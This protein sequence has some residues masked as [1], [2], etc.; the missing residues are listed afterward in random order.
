MV[1]KELPD[2]VGEVHQAPSLVDLLARSLEGIIVE[3]LH[4]LAAGPV[5]QNACALVSSSKAF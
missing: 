1:G 2:V 4:P 5:G 3:R